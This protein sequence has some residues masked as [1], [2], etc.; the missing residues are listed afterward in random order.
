MPTVLSE[1]QS[2]LAAYERCPLSARLDELHPSQTHAQGRGTIAHAFAQEYVTECV[3]LNVPAL[4]V[5]RAKDIMAAAIV[6]SGLPLGANEEDLLMALA[7]KFSTQRFIDVAAVV[8][9]EEQYEIT[10][11]DVI[12]TGRP[13]LVLITGGHAAIHDY[14]TSW[15]IDDQAST[16]GTFQG[17]L[18]AR[19]TFERWPQIHT[20]RVVVDYLRWGAERS[21]EF[22][23]VDIPDMDRLL[24]T[25]VA[26]V[27]RARA[28][29]DEGD[30]LSVEGWPASP[31]RWCVNC[32]APQECPIPTV[33][34][35][36]GSITNAEDAAL[37]A[38]ALVPIDA[39][40]SAQKKALRAWT[41]ENGPV[42]VGDGEWGLDKQRDGWQVIDLETLRGALEAKGLTF[43]EFFKP[44]NGATVFGYRAPKAKA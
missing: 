18:Y 19:L 21:V 33:D 26:R 11:G 5:E 22:T 25:L 10:L 44:R 43:A 9:L 32:A 14:K 42:T 31:G 41:S 34:R 12:V 30:V 1:R 27:A 13:D 37:V 16:E 8:D 6:A 4:E 28:A 35:G 3:T 23:R 20:V 29:E 24:T 39:V 7:W 38:R 36:D 40:V 17:R 2:F 15:A